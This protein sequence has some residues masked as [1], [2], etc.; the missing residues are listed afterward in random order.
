MI[1]HQYVAAG[2]DST[3]TALGNAIYLLATHPDQFDLMRRDRSSIPAAFNEI[4]RYESPIHAFGRL[5]MEDVEIEGT[6]IPAGCPG[7]P[8]LWRCQPDP[9]H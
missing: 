3:I 5:V 9:R 1:I 2:M 4:V 8:A 7:R 6:V